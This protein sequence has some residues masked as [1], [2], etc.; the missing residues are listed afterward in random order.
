MGRG[1]GSAA[2]PRPSVMSALGAQHRDVSATVRRSTELDVYDALR[3]AALWLLAI[4]FVVGVAPAAIYTA[5]L[6]LAAPF[7]RR[8]RVGASPSAR[9]F[10]LLV[11]AHNEEAVLGRTLASLA[12]LDYPADQRDVWLVADNCTDSTAALARAHGARVCERHDLSQPGKGSALAWLLAQIDAAGETYDGYIVVD[13]DSL[14]SDNFLRAMDARLEGG[15][16]AVQGYY[17]V[18]LLHGTRAEALRG[19]ALALVHYL[20]PA[21]KSALGL[22]CGLKGNGMCFAR[23]VIVRFGWP[24]AGLAEDVEFT[25]LLSANNVRVAFA[26]E[27]SVRGE[28]PPT[29]RAAVSQNRR[30]EAG[31]VA[32]ARA[33]IPLLCRGLHRRDAAAVDSAVEQLVP[34]L[35]VPV[36]LAALCSGSGALLAAPWLWLP[37]IAACGSFALYIV[38]GLVLAK[39][40]AAQWRALGFAPLYVLWKLALYGL[41]LAGPR[42]RAW[43]RTRR[44]V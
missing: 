29:L 10:A 3:I 38:A 33:A 25:L 20:R 24:T 39:C 42:Q 6:T 37:S 26:P 15:A 30:W 9:R 22:S 2:E 40:T 41:V 19:V 32:A 23:D 35:S 28:I 1:I 14:L 21:A 5:L 8:Q 27:A 34:P 16:L 11:P 31:R 13:A 12:A 4:V 17:T 7:G 43:V 44:G 18:L 36:V